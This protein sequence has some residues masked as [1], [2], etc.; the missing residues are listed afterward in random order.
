M[1]KKGTSGIPE[2]VDIGSSCQDLLFPK[3][4]GM[5]NKSNPFICSV[6]F[7]SKCYMVIEKR[8]NNI[9]GRSHQST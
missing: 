1:K 3:G 6:H 5:K 8:K 2:S 7:H 4:F 9:S